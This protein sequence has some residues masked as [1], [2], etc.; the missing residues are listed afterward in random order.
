MDTAEDN[1]CIENEQEIKKEVK[2]YGVKSL[3]VHEILELLLSYTISRKDTKQLAHM[4]IEKF[5]GFSQVLDA[6]IS[7]LKKLTGVGD[8]TAVFLHMLPDIFEVY[9][10][11][12]ICYSNIY[13]KTTRQ[14]VDYFRSNFEIGGQEYMYVVC[15]NKTC[16]VVNKFEVKGVDDCTVN[17]DLKEFAEQISLNSVASIVIFHTHPN[18]EATPSEQ[19]IATTQSI[20]NMCAMLRI[21]I[22]DHIILNES[23]HYSFGREG[24]LKEMY[25]KYFQVFAHGE[26][27]PFLRQISNFCCN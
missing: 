8:K 26:A 27:S 12:R 20:L 3:T 9:K 11:E 23:T 17:V 4:L 21:G 10:Q 6:P 14:C 7:E 13:L 24:K 5:G 15:L 22:C 1:S 19:D 2:K 25:D 16:K 18:G